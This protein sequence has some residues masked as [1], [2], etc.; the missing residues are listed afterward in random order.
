[1]TRPQELGAEPAD[2][3]LATRAARGDA[4]AFAA[5]VKR[6]KASLYGYVRR[7]VGS[8][9]DAYDLLQQTFLSAWLAL[10]RYDAE[11]PLLAWLRAIAR[12]KCRDHARKTKVMRVLMIADWPVSAGRVADFR[13]G[14]EE[15][16]I[17]E[18]GLRVMDEAIA[19]LPRALKEPLLLIAFEGLTHLEAGR[20]LGITAKAVETRVSRARRKLAR[21]LN[22]PDGEDR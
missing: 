1:M 22:P 18:E 7:Y 9:D 19:D 8:A 17:E 21:A 10:D 2:A 14:P 13:A 4:P 15:R 20:E 11:L 5:L 16:W 6:H 3:I 12:N